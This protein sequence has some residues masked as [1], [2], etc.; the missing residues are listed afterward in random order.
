MAIKKTGQTPFQFSYRDDLRELPQK[1]LSC[2]VNL[3]GGFTE[4]A[5]TGHVYYGMPGCGIMRASADLAHTDVLELPSELATVNFHSTKIGYLDGNPRLILP[6]NRDEKVAIVTLEGDVEYILARPEFDEYKD[7]DYLPTDV[8]VKEDLLYIADGYGSNYISSAEPKNRA[9]KNIFG[10]KA[11]DALEHGKFGTAHGM[12]PDPEG[13]SLVIADRP[14][15]RIEVSTFRGEH[16]ASHAMPAGS[17]PCGIQF[18]NHKSHWYAVVASL[19]D[20]VEGRAAPIYVLDGI[21]F[22]V[23]STIR[24]KE[25]LGIELAD[26]IHNAVWHEH[27]GRQFLVCQAWNPGFYFILEIE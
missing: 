8:V 25:D 6:A 26:H 17:K 14:N 16:L 21:T 12:N 24:P 2:E 7:A 11:T 9:W 1:A 10:G 27:A 5:A 18:F 20:P 23:I 3:H 15:S 13:K 4:D 19:D 22:E